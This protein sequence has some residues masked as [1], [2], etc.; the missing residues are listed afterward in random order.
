MLPEKGNKQHF[1]RFEQWDPAFVFAS[2][3]SIDALQTPRQAL[4]ELF[5]PQSYA[6]GA[7]KPS[8]QTSSKLS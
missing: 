1:R 7:L 3:Y 8:I 4:Q 6:P 5:I 2:T